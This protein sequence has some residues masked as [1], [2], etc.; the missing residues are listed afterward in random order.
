MA[1]KYLQIFMMLMILPWLL[2]CSQK[3]SDY[4][5]VQ[6]KLDLFEY[7]NGHVI[8]WGMVQDYTNTQTR[9]FEVTILGTVKD[10]QLTLVEDFIFSDGETQ[11][12]IWHITQLSEGLYQGTANDVIGTATGKSQGNAVNW[13]YTLDLPVGDESYQVQFDD[14]MYLQ[15]EHHLFNLADIKKFGI[16]VGQVT[17]FFQKQPATKNPMATSTISKNS[18]SKN[19]EF[20]H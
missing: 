17:L 6:P 16:K 4:Q 11:Q 3:M 9:R 10:N 5:N 20:K 2:S 8:A 15:D 1:S 7:F 19:I 14:W 12:R 13:R 18:I